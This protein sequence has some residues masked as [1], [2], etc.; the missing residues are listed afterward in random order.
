MQNPFKRK[1][2]TQEFTDKG[3][4]DLSF[5][6]GGGRPMAV[7]IGRTPN[8]HVLYGE[9]DMMNAPTTFAR[10]ATRWGDVQLS[11]GWDRTNYGNRTP[12][13][14]M[15]Y[16]NVVQPN[17]PG[18]TRQFGQSTADFPMRGSAPSQWDQ[19]VA[20]TA[21]AQPDYPGGPGQAMGTIFNPGSGA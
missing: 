17:V 8:P 16:L 3:G 11:N 20:M 15:G 13:K 7:Y 6:N 14:G 5:P 18:Q 4:D 10:I 12:Y 1:V 9:D 19:Y 2:G 21:G